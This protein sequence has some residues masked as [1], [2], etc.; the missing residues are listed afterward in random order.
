M[1][2]RKN[3]ARER[4]TRGERVSPLRAPFFPAPITSKRLTATQAKVVGMSLSRTQFS[5]VSEKHAKIWARDLGNWAVAGKRK[6]F[7]SPV[8]SRF[9][10]IIIFYFFIVIFYFYVR[11]FSISRNRLSRSQEQA[12]LFFLCGPRV[13]I[14][15]LVLVLKMFDLSNRLW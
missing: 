12:F 4:D 5:R 1:G 15:N 9:L 3:G 13:M 7:L 11:A 6:P 8:F 2:G 14:V 10:I